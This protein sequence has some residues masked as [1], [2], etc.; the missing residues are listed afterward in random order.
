[1][2]SF[3]LD[4]I[5]IAPE[6]FIE[7]GSV[8][9]GL[10]SVYHRLQQTPSQEIFQSAVDQLWQIALKVEDGDLSEA[11]QRLRSAQD[12]LMKALEEGA[13]DAEIQKLMEELKLAM[14][15]FLRS[16][17]EQAEQNPDQNAGENEAQQ[18]MSAQD[19]QEMLKQ[20]EKLARSGSKEAAQQLLSELRDMLDRLQAGRMARNGQGDQMRQMMEK[21]GG[22]ISKQR[23]LLDKTFRAGRNRGKGSE[24]EGQNEGQGSGE[25]QGERE[26][27]GQL[28]ELNR[29]QGQL[30]KELERLLSEM[31]DL[32]AKARQQFNGAGKNMEQAEESLGDE[33]P[34]NAADEQS[35]ALDQLRKG[36]QAMT[37]QMMR[38][39]NGQMGS[40]GGND[41]R[42]PFGRAWKSDGPE[43]DG[44]STK[45][46]R[47][48]DVQ[49]ARRILDEL[50]K[51]LGETTRSPLELDYLERLLK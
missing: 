47:E 13:S 3:A 2:P 11:E 16:L 40:R 43:A 14:S 21:F 23:K 4:A 51:R 34:E 33:D 39:A 28:D 27:R 24:S 29:D 32:D 36:A 42:D 10:R 12:R 17:A 1:M 18:R 30:R 8:Y 20:I 45:V 25:G 41:D 22:M 31:D 19:L 46:P 5:T 35:R 37:E 15:E 38:G 44:G 50:R 6:K 48:I 7:D 9:L 26:W 49:R